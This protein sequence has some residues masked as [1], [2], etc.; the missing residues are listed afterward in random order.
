MESLSR[1]CSWST[2]RCGG[3]RGREP[4]AMITTSARRVVS[5]PSILLI[6]SVR[7]VPAPV[8]AAATKLA[9]PRSKVM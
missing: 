6:E 7:G 5:E 1:M 4:V 2:A 3:V 8:A 9:R